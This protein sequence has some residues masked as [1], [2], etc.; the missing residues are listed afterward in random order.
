MPTRRQSGI[1]LLRILAMIGIV[2]R[3]YATQAG[4]LNVFEQN[5]S[6]NKYWLEI[7]FN[8]LGKVGVVLFFAITAWFLC[9]RSNSLKNCCKRV[10]IMERELLFWSLTIA[11]TLVVMRVVTGQNT[12]GAAA[13]IKSF[14]PLST[15][16]WWYP[17]SY[18]VFLV[19][20]PFLNAGLRIMNQKQHFMMVVVTILMW[21][22]IGGWV[23]QI[24]F[25][26]VEMNFIEFVYLFVL[27][28]YFKLYGIV[29][30]RRISILMILGGFLIVAIYVFATQFMFIKTNNHADLQSYIVDKAWT[31]PVLL[32][33]FGMFS[34]ALQSRMENRAVNWIAKSAFATYLI[35]QHPIVANYLWNNTFDFK[36]IYE[37]AWLPFASLGTI[38]LVFIVCTLLD[39]VRRG[40]FAFTCD[41]KRGGWFEKAWQWLDPEG[42]M[43][44]LQKKIGRSTETSE[45]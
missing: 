36:A 5:S 23:P 18:A 32:I 12:I 38:V 22:I 42:K 31:L 1:E 2:A 21:T 45:I 11:A 24:Q 41:R 16:L 14:L 29:V 13:I 3:H 17:T 35:S 10:W 6:L 44:S 39:L 8:P 30:P 28:S 7:F 9:D 33:S 20:L 40:I 34:I 27:I 4:S 26:M 15:D 19:I 43:E 37:S 25:D